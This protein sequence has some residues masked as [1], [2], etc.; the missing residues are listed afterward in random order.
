M[1]AL[2]R[3]HYSRNLPIHLRDMCA[4]QKLH[5]DIYRE[6]LSGKFVGQKTKHVFSSLGLDQM[7][8]QLIGTLKGDGG[9]IRLTEDLT[10]LRR[11]IVLGL[12]FQKLFKNLRTEKNLQILN[13]MNNI[14]NSKAL[15]KMM[16]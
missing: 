2:D 4:L 15:F 9:V 14:L 16:S 11:N 1:F 3:I 10:L 6:F 12:N 8:E 7:H 5:P 13:I